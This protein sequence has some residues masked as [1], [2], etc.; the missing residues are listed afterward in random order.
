VS[1]YDS[2]GNLVATTT[3]DSHGS[4]KFTSLDLGAYTVKAAVAWTKSADYSRSVDLSRGIAMA[5]IDLGLKSDLGGR[6]QG[7]GGG[8][9][10]HG[11]D[12]GW[13]PW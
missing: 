9:V 12:N 7:P 8:L 5:G 4:Y 3:T 2:S 1:L 11:W 6:Y 10:G 13:F